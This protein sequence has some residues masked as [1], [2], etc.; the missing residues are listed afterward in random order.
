MI[1]TTKGHNRIWC[2]GHTKIKVIC[3]IFTN[4]CLSFDW[5]NESFSLEGWLFFLPLESNKSP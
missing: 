2:V 3:L 1:S 5:Y 4:Q